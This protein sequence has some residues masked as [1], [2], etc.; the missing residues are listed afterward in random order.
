M[1]FLDEDE[2]G[3]VKKKPALNR[4]PA[5]SAKAQSPTKRKRA[6]E[7]SGEDEDLQGSKSKS[8]KV[9]RPV[10]RKKEASDAEDEDDEDDAYPTHG[11]RHDPTPPPYPGDGSQ[12][13]HDIWQ[14][15][16]GRHT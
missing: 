11:P 4:E 12:E 15:H 16:D 6:A 7:E 14:G 5:P 8:V 2:D 9:K 10:K 13:L 1:Y 3:A